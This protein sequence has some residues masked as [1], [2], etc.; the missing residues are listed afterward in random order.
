MTATTQPPTSLGSFSLF[1][2][3]DE[4]ELWHPNILREIVAYPPDVTLHFYLSAC[5]KCRRQTLVFHGAVHDAGSCVTADLY[6]PDT[7][8]EID[9][10]RERLNLPRFATIKPRYSRSAGRSYISQG[11]HHC[12]ALLGDQYMFVA[13]EITVSG[14]TPRV[15]AW[16]PLSLCSFLSDDDSSVWHSLAHRFPRTIELSRS[17]VQWTRDEEVALLDGFDRGQSIEQLADA[18]RRG[19]VAVANRLARLGRY[20]PRD[21]YLVQLPRSI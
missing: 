6:W 20:E 7:I 1:E 10:I 13:A 15:G 3:L 8:R 11:C 18:H 12:D 19:K 21:I 2:D 17:A 9:A 16:P 5:W 14:E 4:P